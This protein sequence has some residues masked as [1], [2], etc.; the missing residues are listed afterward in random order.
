MKMRPN[1]H[2]RIIIANRVDTEV[3]DEDSIQLFWTTYG[4]DGII[5][6][7]CSMGFV[8]VLSLLLLLLMINWKLYHRRDG[9]V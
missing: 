5:L 6:T 2:S 8:A 9:Q 1:V 7:K 4:N 3:P